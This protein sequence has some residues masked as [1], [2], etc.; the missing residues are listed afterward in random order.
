MDNQ[1]ADNQPKDKMKKADA[2][3]RE[4]LDRLERGEALDLKAFFSAHGELEE[5]LWERF[6]TWE[7][8]R[9]V[10][11]SER[12]EDE[13][14]SV[15]QNPELFF[16]FRDD[17]GE[18]F[19]RRIGEFTLLKEIGRG[20]MGVVFLARQEVTDRL[21]ALKLLSPLRHK[22]P[23]ARERFRREVAALGRLHHRNVVSILTAGDVE[24]VPYFAMELVCGVQMNDILE[25][26]KGKDP[27][28]ISGN[29][30]E[31]IIEEKVPEYLRPF[32]DVFAPQQSTAA[33]NLFGRPMVEV[34]CRFAIQLAEALAHAHSQ[35][36]IHRDVKPSNIL[37]DLN[38][39]CRLSDFGLA[40]ELG[41]SALTKTGELVGTPY[42]A[43]PEQIAGKR[44]GL[45]NRADIFSLGV[46]FYELLCLR[47]PFEGETTERVFNQILVKDPKPPSTFNA[48]VPRDVETIVFKCLEKDPDHR[49]QT[50]GE[51][52]EDLRAFLEFRPIRARPVGPIK[53]T[54]KLI[55]RHRLV[56][57]AL[58]VAVL[59]V[60][61]LAGYM[62]KVKLDKRSAERVILEQVESEITVIR[63]AIEGKSLS[64][65]EKSFE[66]LAA[67][68]DTH[69][70]LEELRQEIA[71][72]RCDVR[73]GDVQKRKEEYTRSKEKRAE[74]EKDLARL[75]ERVSS[76]YTEENER[77]RAADLE[78]ELTV[79]NLNMAD[80]MDQIIYAMND[81]RAQAVA[82]GRQKYPPVMATFAEYFL[83][84]WREAHDA[85]NTISM[86]NYARFVKE[87]DLEGR[88]TDEVEGTGKLAVKGTSGAK[89]WLFRYESYRS[90][91][92]NA[93]LD[94]LVPVPY[95]CAA[96]DAEGYCRFGGDFYAGDPCLLVTHQ[97]LTD[98][99]AGDLVFSVNGHPAG[100]SLF[101]EEVLAG[102]PADRAGV[103]PFHRIVKID[104]VDRVND[105]IWERGRPSSS[106]RVTLS[107]GEREFSFLC[108]GQTGTFSGRSG[109]RAATAAG[110]L[111]NAAA[112]REIVLRALR[113]GNEITLSIQE[114][115]VAG[116]QGEVTAYPLVC[117]SDNEI[118]TLPLK[119]FDCS[120]G[121]CL[122]V[123]RKK[124]MEEVRL[125][126]LVPRQGV[127]LESV[128][129]LP[130]GTS[131]PGFV[132]I[133]GGKFTSGGDPEALWSDDKIV[134]SVK[135]FWIS[136]K[137][138]TNREWFEFVN[139]HETLSKI[140]R[141]RENGE[142]RYLPRYP[143]FDMETKTA[144]PTE[145]T[146]AKQNEMTGQWESLWTDP[147]IPAIGLSLEDISDFLKWKNA[148]ARSRG[149]RWTYALPSQ[150]E[151]E[152][153]ARGVDQRAFP[154]GNRFD[155]TF[156]KSKYSLPEAILPENTHLE[157]VFHYPIDESPYCVRDLA[158][159]VIEWNRDHFRHEPSIR[160]GAYDGN[161][162]ELF[163]V[164]SRD[165]PKRGKTSHNLGFRLVAH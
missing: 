40:R 163:R 76:R 56:S 129:L 28:T 20:T 36:V 30:L 162:P 106:F 2:V 116:I 119:P 18:E 160:G 105:F 86:S 126:V 82:A 16:A 9:S 151:W 41:T 93:R 63:S 123:I 114:G 67:L 33:A 69:P 79:L 25:D 47:V 132:R 120:P 70:D 157:P 65:A 38:G 104:M 64:T 146:L 15:I 55:R 109:I 3:F 156:C 27:L 48:G 87:Y 98:L 108:P 21:V 11:K 159:S 149:E 77:M 4:Y 5:L 94:R 118:G 112:P 53:S 24:D 165:N 13:V 60:F 26:L 73:L 54:I 31:D 139:D 66:R 158:G 59:A 111:A 44:M 57:A 124:G 138:V 148:K 29:R 147:E 140:A 17:R 39:Q 85:S 12:Q 150:A 164:A 46:T 88:F 23:T 137:E 141:A 81:A 68:D 6:W 134:K 61:I 45:D 100:E 153:A 83:D 122:V 154:W 144:A 125:P 19:G 113:D 133:V 91:S 72:L 8:A 107:D 115:D 155:F 51:L 121:S 34:A 43:A 49:Y 131:P 37:V 14:P 96:R 1:P 32:S 75:K 71:L 62:I 102:G 92:R 110:L 99:E 127:H 152:K 74:L 84:R 80:M 50:A 35:G 136:K 78:H 52:A 145:V 58:G 42:Y 95:N 135:E 142:T 101:V 89:V 103:E 10:F 143:R 128:K 7:E 90:T 130:A 97:G 161:W 22:S 117:C